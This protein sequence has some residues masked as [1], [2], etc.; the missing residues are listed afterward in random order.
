MG[1]LKKD[2]QVLR[3][4]IDV[5]EAEVVSAQG[6]CGAI[7]DG[8]M[9]A[10]VKQAQELQASLSASEEKLGRVMEEAGGL[11][12]EVGR[13]SRDV[14]HEKACAEKAT[15][16]L[17]VAEKALALVRSDMERQGG[18]LETWKKIAEG[19]AGE[20]SEAVVRELEGAQEALRAAGRQV[21]EAELKEQ[22][23]REGRE[24]AEV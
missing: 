13:L 21:E 2:V 14:E 3:A 5:L 19:K 1:D 4:R 8:D 12:K 15:E 22:H 20:A 7:E 18:D 17:G 11:R 24:A 23:E 9:A 10:V 6:L 16:E